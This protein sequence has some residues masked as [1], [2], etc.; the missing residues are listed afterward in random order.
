M[1]HAAEIVELLRV[2]NSSGGSAPACN[3]VSKAQIII[4]NSDQ[5][6]NE[7]NMIL[8]R[9]GGLVLVETIIGPLEYGGRVQVWYI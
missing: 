4:A 1:Y 5:G 7:E 8:K 2:I 6:K 9:R 3:A